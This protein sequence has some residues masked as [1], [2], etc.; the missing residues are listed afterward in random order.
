MNKNIPGF[1]FYR[2]AEGGGSGG[3]AG[4]GGGDG[5]TKPTVGDAAASSQAASSAS[6][7]VPSIGAQPAK[8][9]AA[10][11]FKTSLGDFGKEA[12]FADVKDAQQLAKMYK[13][14]KT[15][16]G[17]KLGIP[18]ENA[19]PEAKA[20]FYKALGVPD[21][22]DG[23]GLDKLPDDA[24]D[25]LKQHFDAEEAK[26]WSG[27]FKKLN[28]PAPA[29]K[30]LQK[31][32]M[33]ML[34]EELKGFKAD[35]SKSDEQ[36]DALA[37]KTFGEKKVEALQNARALM[38][39]HT[40]KEAFSTLKDL[41]NDRLVAVAEFISNFTKEMT[42]EDQVLKGDAG[43]S[44]Q[45]ESELRQEMRTIMSSPEFNSPFSPKGKDGHEEAKKKVAEISGKIA[46]IR[47]KK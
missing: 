46:A 44:A 12:M 45:S 7:S 2:N 39:K 29:A 15:L 6:A 36:F 22:E 9:D 21:S 32:M 24:P 8:T 10:P 11:D 33:T 31:E 14:T 1:R 26:K 47:N 41:P 28:I 35:E 16:V 19:T 34:G 17:Q 3:D 42:G 43:G 23:Y 20:A 40:S 38:E 30:E 25:E 5:G 18:D 13:D 37:T 27:I 4:A